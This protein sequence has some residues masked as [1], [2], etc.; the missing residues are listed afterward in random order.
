MHCHFAFCVLIFNVTML[1]RKI[2]VGKKFIEAHLIPLQSKNLIVL[3]GSRGY[4]MCGYLN[5]AAANKFKDVAIKIVGVSTI[6]DA[7]LAPAHSLSAAAKK[8]GIR[9]GKVIKDILEGI[10]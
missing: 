9:K 10:V 7:L 5:L 3:K 2:K 8:M 6:K 4:V 1:Y